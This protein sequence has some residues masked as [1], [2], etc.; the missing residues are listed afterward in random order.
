MSTE[1]PV[2]LYVDDNFESR[3]VMKILLSKDLKLPTYYIWDETMNDPTEY[4]R[5][6]PLP[7]IVF[8]DIFM[9]PY[10]G[11]TLLAKIRQLPAYRHVPIVALTASVM[12]DEITKL[13]KA[14]FDGVI[15]KPVNQLTFPM[16]L[17]KLMQGDQYWDI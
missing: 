9:E 8:L 13:Q 15:A 12:N 4:E 3:M 1:Y 5:L 6:D 17:D 14:E 16:I 7:D 10:D 11:F 2:I